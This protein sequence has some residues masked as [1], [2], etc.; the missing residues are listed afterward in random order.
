MAQTKPIIPS[1]M[2][3]NM[4]GKTGGYRGNR[5]LFFDGTIVGVPYTPLDQYQLRNLMSMAMTF[6]DDGKPVHRVYLSLVGQTSNAFDATESVMVSERYLN[7]TYVIVRPDGGNEDGSDDKVCLHVIGMQDCPDFD[8]LDNVSYVFDPADPSDI[9]ISDIRWADADIVSVVDDLDYELTEDVHFSY[10]ST[11]FTV[12]TAYLQS[13]LE[14]GDSDEAVVCRELT[15]TLNKDCD[16][17]TITVCIICGSDS[18][19]VSSDSDGQG[20]QEPL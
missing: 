11:S 5:V 14:C 6:A 10:T 2:Y 4:L 15:I 12:E 13:N 3:R 17:I 8:D 20:E 19:G 9:V 1:V 18:D 16:P 7:S